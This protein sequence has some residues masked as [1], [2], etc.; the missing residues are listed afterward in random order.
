MEEDKEAFSTLRY[1]TANLLLFKQTLYIPLQVSDT[2][3]TPT[4]FGLLLQNSHNT[5][6]HDATACCILRSF[7]SMQ[8]I[9]HLESGILSLS[10]HMYTIRDT[11]AATVQGLHRIA[12]FTD[13]ST[14]PVYN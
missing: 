10:E 9:L 7:T 12:L 4:D 13:V 5:N 6:R 11:Q 1:T 8:R 14:E 2:S 3:N